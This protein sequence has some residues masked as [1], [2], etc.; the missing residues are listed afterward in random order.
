MAANAS[1]TLMSASETAR[2]S[3]WFDFLCL[4]PILFVMAGAFHLSMMLTVGDWDFWLDWKDRQWWPLVTPLLAITFPAAVQYVLWT[5]FRIPLG[6]TVTVLALIIRYGHHALF[7]LSPVDQLSDQHGATGHASPERF[8]AGRHIAFV[9]EFLCHAE[10]SRYGT[11]PLRATGR[12]W[13]SRCPEGIR[14]AES[15]GSCT[16]APGTQPFSP[17]EMVTAIERLVGDA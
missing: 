8:G 4:V 1:E 3:R 13:L 7:C 12:S 6:A 15:V 11:A 5:N 14:G 2:L 10:P 16:E 9:Q 17:N